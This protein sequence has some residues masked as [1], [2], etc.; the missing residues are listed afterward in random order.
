M[1][2]EEKPE[3]I[4][5]KN[6]SYTDSALVWKLKPTQDGFILRSDQLLLN[7]LQQNAFAK[8]VYFAADVP[9][10]MRLFLDDNLQCKGLTYRLVPYKDATIDIELMSRLKRLPVLSAEVTSYLNNRD[11]IQ[12]LNNY[13]FAYT[14]AAISASRNGH[15]DDALQL[16]ETSENKYPENLLPFFADVTKQWFEQLKAKAANGEKL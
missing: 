4:P 15:N 2:W 16:I 11:N 7:I 6:E 1:R 3:A 9:S 5:I 14:A 12:V 13:R 10:N 8:P